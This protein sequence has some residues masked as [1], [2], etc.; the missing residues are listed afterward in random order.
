MSNRTFFVIAVT[1]IATIGVTIPFISRAEKSKV[2]LRQNL[3]SVESNSKDEAGFSPV[4]DE[5]RVVSLQVTPNGFEPR[6]TTAR[7]GKFLILLQNRTGRRD[8]RFYLIRENQERLAGSQPQ[9][10]DWKAHVQLGPGTYIVGEADHPDWQSI[11][12]VTN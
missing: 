7:P 11:I 9:Q 2:Y 4:D 5:P 3:A 1:F 10:R 6:E 12:R 8:L